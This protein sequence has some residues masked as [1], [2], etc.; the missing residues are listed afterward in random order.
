MNQ[1]QPYKL[2][3]D[4]AGSAL[5]SRLSAKHQDRYNGTAQLTQDRVPVSFQARFSDPNLC[6]LQTHWRTVKERFK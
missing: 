1:L 5:S 3:P 6:I 2:L 4:S